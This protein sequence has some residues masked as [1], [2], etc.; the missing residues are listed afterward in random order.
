MTEFSAL[1]SL[2]SQFQLPPAPE[3]PTT[4]WVALEA[5]G[6]NWGTIANFAVAAATFCLACIAVRQARQTEEIIKATNKQAAELQQ[7]NGILSAQL[8]IE[9]ARQYPTLICIRSI[10]PLTGGIELVNTGRHDLLVFGA[11]YTTEKQLLSGS[12]SSDLFSQIRAHSREIETIAPSRK[13]A[14]QFYVIP[15]A[16]RFVVK[17][18]GRRLPCAARMYLAVAAA[19]PNVGQVVLILPLTCKESAYNISGYEELK[20]IEYLLKTN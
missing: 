5:T 6:V 8:E 2:L 7:Q 10:T 4:V 17:P 15:H 1:P 18:G 16:G 13:D 14:G 3:V 12:A 19:Y 9:R 20:P 11:E